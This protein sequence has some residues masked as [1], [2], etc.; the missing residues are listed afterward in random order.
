MKK[1]L[2]YT[3]NW[4]NLWEIFQNERLPLIWNEKHYNYVFIIIPC[5]RAH[6]IVFTLAMTFF[7]GCMVLH[8]KMT[9]R[10]RTASHKVVWRFP[11]QLPSMCYSKISNKLDIAV[12]HHA[13]PCLPHDDHAIFLHASHC[14]V[15]GHLLMTSGW[16]GEHF[17][18]SDGCQYSKTN[19]CQKLSLLKI[20]H[21]QLRVHPS[22]KPISHITVWICFTLY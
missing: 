21:F 17:L 1:I 5:I 20:M 18:G 3:A 14:V 7:D 16:Q 4:L 22:N 8:G 11:M 2:L 6:D 15:P 9:Y 13:M 19:H 10:C 12:R